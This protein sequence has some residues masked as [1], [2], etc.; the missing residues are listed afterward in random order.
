MKN[1]ELNAFPF[2]FR[3]TDSDKPVHEHCVLKFS[4]I[5]LQNVEKHIR[6]RP[7]QSAFTDV[8]IKIC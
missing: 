4:P 8:V 7:T 6:Q 2:I 5:R 3:I 1:R